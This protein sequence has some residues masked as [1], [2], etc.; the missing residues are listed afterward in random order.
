MAQ[1]PC[2]RLINAIARAPTA[3]LK[4]EVINKETFYL[5]LPQEPKKPAKHPVWI[6]IRV[7]KLGEFLLNIV[8]NSISPITWDSAG[9]LEVQLRGKIFKLNEQLQRLEAHDFSTPR[10]LPMAR[11]FTVYIISD[12]IDWSRLDKI[13]FDTLERNKEPLLRTLYAI[14]FDKAH[15]AATGAAADPGLVQKA[16]IIFGTFSDNFDTENMEASRAISLNG[17]EEVVNRLT[18]ML[19]NP[20]Y[21]DRQLPGMLSGMSSLIHHL[22]SDKR[23]IAP[24]VTPARIH[25]LMMQRFWEYQPHRSNDRMGLG[26]SGYS[27]RCFRS[28]MLEVGNENF[29]LGQHVFRDLVVDCD[30]I[31][32]YGMGLVGDEAQGNL[33]KENSVRGFTTLIWK[34][35]QLNPDVARTHVV[36][37]WMRVMD[38]LRRVD[39]S[40]GPLITRGESQNQESTIALWAELGDSLKI[41]ESEVREHTRRKTSGVTSSK[42]IACNNLKC[43]L[44]VS[45]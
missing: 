5:N 40:R 37:A 39:T 34:Y 32:A 17:V 16:L 28:D 43:P 33:D 36:P 2:Q 15:L 11:A 10:D 14:L 24:M 3:M 18:M 42:L 23:A 31:A 4:G 1:S 20:A 19:H 7:S 12:I 6:D 25:S 27:G 8:T 13:F 30:F 38:A 22:W 9:R 44:F 35:S 41:I 29:L 26:P 45:S 21:S